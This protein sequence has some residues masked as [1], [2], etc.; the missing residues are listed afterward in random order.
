MA[1]RKVSN[2]LMNIVLTLGFIK[3]KNKTV[4]VIKRNTSIYKSLVITT[5]ESTLS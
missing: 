5:D 4:F 1:F 3:T 2:K